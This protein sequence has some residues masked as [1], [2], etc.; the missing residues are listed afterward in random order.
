MRFFGVIVCLIALILTG[1][2]AIT[3]Q[4][5]KIQD[6]ILVRT[7]QALADMAIDPID[8]IVDGRHVTLRGTI[9]DDKNHE[10]LLRVA[11]EVWG[12]L[13]P[14][15]ELERLT[16]IAPYRFEATKDPEG[17]T[18]IEGLAP[19]A[20]LRDQIEGDAKAI[21]G[22]DADVRIDL[23]AGAPDG[24]WRNIAGLGMDALATLRQGK[25]LIVDQDLSLIGDVV[26][27]SDVEAVDIFADAVPEGFIWTNELSI[28]N[29]SEAAAG[30]DQTTAEPTATIGAIEP[31]TFKIIK[32]TDGSMNISGFA[33]DEATR[34]IMIDQAKSVAVDRPII[35]DIRIAEGMPDEGWPDLVFAGFGAM[36]QVEAGEYEVI[37]SD[38]S[39][40]GDVIDKNLIQESV[41][42][43]PDDQVPEATIETTDTTEETTD[44]AATTDATGQDNNT[45]QI[46]EANPH[47]MT[48]YKTD[49]NTLLLQGLVPDEATRD[50]LI[51][52]L[53]QKTGISEIKA[54]IELDEGVTD[55]TW[56]DLIADRSVALTAVRSGSI[57]FADGEVHLIGVVDTPEDIEAVKAQLAEIDPSMTADLNPIDP[58]SAAAIE[59][60]ISPG[61]GVTLWGDLPDG[62]TEKETIEA[63]GLATYEGGLSQGGRGSTDAWRKN[64]VAIGSYLPQFEHVGIKLGENGSRIEGKLHTNSD[65]DQ[66]TDGLTK[67]FG[68]DKNTVI[69]ISTTELTHEDGS[70]RQNPLTGKQEVYDRGYWLPVV[71]FSSELLEC[72]RQSTEILESEKITF[73]RGQSALDTRAEKIVD[74]LAA[75]AIKCLENK[76]LTLE[77]GGHTDARGADEMN[78]SLSQDRANAILRSLAERGVDPVSILAT[79]YGASQPVADNKTSEGRAKNR[80]ITFEW[81][82]AGT[83]G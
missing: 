26:E 24:D 68:S 69:D 56:L 55:D 81:K 73:L 78:Q 67:L 45:D 3:Y 54:D 71:A 27:S 11:G 38:V 46:A 51:T 32:N 7:E 74:N 20:E 12:G 64:L 75:I 53:G 41:T 16:V 58:R 10:E 34:Q 72:R 79:G 60:V 40:N 39:F 33:P 23:A 36:A 63:L 37:G 83:E 5:P 14:V 31:F 22:E 9:G 30:P 59:L 1:Y 65:I 50:E 62:L 35:S 28:P 25:L 6:D 76:K 15:D 80:R 19:N 77:I 4:A 17:H 44:T 13:G 43:K 18:V 49:D 48:L 42:S 2:S 47:A 61:K 82:E 52:V 8:I 29:Q 66:V 70:K 57:S 21:F